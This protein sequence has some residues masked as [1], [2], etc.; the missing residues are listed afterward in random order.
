MAVRQTRNLAMADEEA[1]PALNG[2]AGNAAADEQAPADEDYLE[3]LED[4]D[5]VDEDVDVQAR[6]ALV[7]C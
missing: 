7:W 6:L 3:D 1:A 5:Y 2:E 4:D